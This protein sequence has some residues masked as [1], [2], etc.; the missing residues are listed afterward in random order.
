MKTKIVVFYFCGQQGL[1]V[2]F[3]ACFCCV[4]Q[5]SES[6]DLVGCNYFQWY[7]EQGIEKSPKNKEMART[8]AKIEE[9]DHESPKNNEMI[10]TV[11][12]MEERDAEKM[13][14]SN[15]E[16][17]FFMLEKWLKVLMGMMF[18]VC[19]FIVIVIYESSMFCCKKS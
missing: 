9:M 5:Q 17:F 1:E 13:K 11:L 19:V 18:I 16:N 4:V 2:C 3:E 6:E 8:V 12:K 14:I 7:S 15:L 10:D